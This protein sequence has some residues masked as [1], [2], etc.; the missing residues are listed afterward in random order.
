MVGA[1]LRGIA[2]LECEIEAF[3]EAVTYWERGD[4]RLLENSDKYRINLIEKKDGYK[5]RDRVC[6]KNYPLF[7]F[8][9]L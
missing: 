5:V 7:I 4:G 3:P 1:R 2:I 8:Y 6:K 9:F